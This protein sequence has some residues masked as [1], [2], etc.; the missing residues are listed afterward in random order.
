MKRG[1][2]FFF[3]VFFTSFIQEAPPKKQEQVKHKNS[4]YFIDVPIVKFTATDVPCLSVQVD[5]KTF[6][7]EFDLGF[8]GD[9]SF[10]PQYLEQ[11]KNKTHLKPRKMYGVRGKEYEHKTYKIH[12]VRIGA[13]SFLNPTLQEESE[14]FLKD[15]TLFE[16]EPDIGHREKG[17]LGWELFG[18][19]NLLID[20]KGQKIAFCDS[21][22]TLKKHR[23]LVKDFIKAPLLLGRGLVE[24]AAKTEKRS[25]LCMLDT[26]ATY[27]I[28]NA[29][30]EE[31]PENGVEFA[32]FEIGGKELG[33][34]SFLQHPIKIP[35]HIEAILGMEFFREHLVFLDFS[36]GFAYIEKNS[37]LAHHS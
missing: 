33:P 37:G 12:R 24:V 1:W 23:Y 26:G 22:K 14:E 36:E 6:L 29:E 10:L 35:I 4:H 8:R 3:V 32:S 28:L 20:I 13:M 30:A 31:D 25:L 5:G 16:K 15:A 9:C 27:N 34:I 2:G 19:T 7:V 18:H 11:V 21:L 17:S